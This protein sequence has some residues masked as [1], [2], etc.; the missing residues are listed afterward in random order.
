[1][2]AQLFP[3]DPGLTARMV[4][5]TVATPLAVLA[6]LA[7]VVALA[8][9]RII[10]FV[11]LA[12]IVGVV[13]SIKE[14]ERAAAFGAREAPPEVH[15]TVERLCLAADLPKPEVVVH[16]ERQPNSWIVWAG[17]RRFRLHLTE[18]LLECLEPRELEA[19]IAHELAHVAHRDATVMTVV[20]GPGAVLLGGG[21]RIMR[22]WWPMM[23]GGIVAMAIGW[24]G[25]LG[26]RMLSRYREFAADAGAV[27]LTG[28]PAALASALTKVSE[29]SGHP[30]A[31]PARRGGA[32]RVPPAAGG[33]V[34]APAA[35]DA[36][37]AEGAHRAPGA[38]GGA[39]AGRAPGAASLIA[40]LCG[41]ETGR[42]KGGYAR[43]SPGERPGRSSSTAPVTHRNHV[44]RLRVAIRR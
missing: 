8:P 33:G 1:M 9:L 10:V 40:A 2:K 4:A 25:S 15:A 3:R 38:D 19:V 34:R 35:R 43:S 29:G 20:G 28:S 16:A 6:C 13:A 21:Q 41:A 18:G 22:G 5:A 32:G 31:R 12:G 42:G 14:R 11:A 37:A 17:H 23:L 36:P 26:G 24:V 39:A 44:G 30:V 27:A 7:A